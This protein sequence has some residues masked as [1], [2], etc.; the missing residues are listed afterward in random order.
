MFFLSRTLETKLRS[1][2]MDARGTPASCKQ[3]DARCCTRS[4]TNLAVKEHI[5]KICVQ[6][7][8]EV[9]VAV[10]VCQLVCL[11][12]CSSVSICSSFRWLSSS[13][14]ERGRPAC[15]EEVNPGDCGFTQLSCHKMRKCLS[16]QTLFRT[17][18]RMHFPGD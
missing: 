2:D 7:Q 13:H 12:L 18:G 3:K 10:S 16:P 9:C 17:P 11:A 4:R 14:C 1:H 6:I 8:T 5:Q 15:Y